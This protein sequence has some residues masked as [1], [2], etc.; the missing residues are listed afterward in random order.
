MIPIFFINMK[1]SSDRYTYIKDQLIKYPNKRIDAFDYNS[2]KKEDLIIDCKDIEYNKFT[3]CVCNFYVFHLR[4]V[5]L[6]GLV[7]A[8]W[9]NFLLYV[10]KEWQQNVPYFQKEL[11]ES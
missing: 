3:A 11:Y 5:Y 7:K 1:R 9:E 10:L 6:F 4:K 2:T 8:K